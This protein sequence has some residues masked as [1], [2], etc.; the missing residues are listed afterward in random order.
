MKQQRQDD[1]YWFM[2]PGP[3]EPWH[4]SNNDVTIIFFMLRDIKS[5]GNGTF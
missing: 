4:M 3:K 2:Y 5:D 1:L